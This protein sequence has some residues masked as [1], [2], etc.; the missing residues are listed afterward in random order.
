MPAPPFRS[1]VIVVD[2]A[3]SDGSADMVCQEFPSVQLIASQV[4]RGFTGGNNLGL[5]Q[6]RGRYVL[7]LNP[8]TEVIGDAL[9]QMIKYME[10]H[11]STGV[12][13]PRLLYPDG[14]VQPSRRRFPTLATA[15]LESTLLQQWW[16]ENE[17]LRRYYIADV[18][19]DA[20]QEVDWLV[21]AC[22]LLRRKTLEQVGPFDEGF[23]MYF[24]ELDW[25]HRCRAQGWKVVYLPTA[26]IIHHEGSSSGQV[27]A[28]RHLHF[29]RSKLYYVRKYMGV[30][31]AEALRLF[32]LATHACQWLEE[33]VKWLIGHK[34]PL[35]RQRLSVYWQVLRSGLK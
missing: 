16:P 12:L 8:D 27:I 14:R 20:V 13:G 2:N 31:Q 15:F 5:E 22:L 21:G 9:A 32:L 1:E 11:P 4:N 26:Q 23:F 18:P 17:T 3:S 25:C 6:S 24:E 30:W 34:R 33:G 35:R 10:E 28:T 7:L 19:D 29:Q